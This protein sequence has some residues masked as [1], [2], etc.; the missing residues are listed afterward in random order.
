MLYDGFRVS[1]FR[2]C[3]LVQVFIRIVECWKQ[4]SSADAVQ[5]EDG[6]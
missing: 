1:E 3:R 2:K 4:E 6:E 5:L